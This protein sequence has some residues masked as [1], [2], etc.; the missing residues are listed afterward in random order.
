MKVADVPERARQ[1]L[2]DE[3]KGP[4]H[5]LEADLD[6]DAGGILDVVARRLHEARDLTQ[7]GEHPAGAL[8]ELLLVG[9]V[10]HH[11]EAEP[12]HSQDDVCP[13][14]ESDAPSDE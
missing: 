10:G 2:V 5:A 7:L 11:G 14:E 9:V 6:V 13:A 12:V 4:A 3:A 1:I 8:V